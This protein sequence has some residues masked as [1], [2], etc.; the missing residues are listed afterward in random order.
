MG[1]TSKEA[2][3]APQVPGEEAG[4]LSR[5]MKEPVVLSWRPVKALKMQSEGHTENHSAFPPQ[6]LGFGSAQPLPWPREAWRPREG[7][8][9]AME[10]LPSLET[11]SCSVW[12]PTSPDS[13]H[14]GS[15]RTGVLLS[16]LHSGNMGQHNAHEAWG[17][18]PG[19]E[20][21]QAD[22]LAKPQPYSRLLPT[23]PLGI[24]GCGED[25]PPPRSCLAGRQSSECGIA[26]AHPMGHLLSPRL[27]VLHSFS[28]CVLLIQPR[29]RM[30]CDSH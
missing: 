18:S 29:N 8:S 24:Q 9:L 28:G 14:P 6:I 5:E 12:P 22:C 21:H 20:K 10:P 15:S 13:H 11:L 23:L 1:S 3:L 16:T 17:Q 7:H 25:T 19:K 27:L 2:C 26:Q 4:T 30:M